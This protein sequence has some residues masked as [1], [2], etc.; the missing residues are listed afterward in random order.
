MHEL[1]NELKKHYKCVEDKIKILEKIANNAKKH[2]NHSLRILKEWKHEDYYNE[3]SKSHS[4]K[5]FH[6]LNTITFPNE[7]TAEVYIDNLYKWQKILSELLDYEKSNDKWQNTLSKLKE[8][9][10][11]AINR[12][13]QYVQ[14][15]HN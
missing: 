1:P 6:H 10:T 2:E 5:I 14:D 4:T 3:E 13:I 9:N 15:I 11:I 12:Y 8:K 7:F